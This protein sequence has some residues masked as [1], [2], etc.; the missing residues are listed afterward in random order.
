MAKN[1]RFSRTEQLIGKPALE[2]LRG[3]SVAVF[4]IGGVGCYAAEAL[5]RSGVG[6]LILIDDDLVCE[7]NINRQ[8]HALDSTVGMP[9][10]EAMRNRIADIN[11]AAVV[12]TLRVFYLPGTES[13]SWDYDYVIDAVDTV[14]AK[15]DIIMESQK[16]GVP[17]I[18]AMGAGNKL[19][20]TKFEIADIY[21]TSICPL[22]KV[23]R[24]EL[25]K[26]GVESL[27]VVYS[28]EPPIRQRNTLIGCRNGCICPPGTRRTC[29][30]RRQIPASVAFVPSVMGL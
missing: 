8:L 2:R 19:D 26:R 11:P 16:R 27:K 1:H 7:T 20:P 3:S 18:S 21:Q 25:K 29:T 17:V 9:K 6:K 22:A 28:K 24:R 12:E 14:T 23:M 10:V 13:V 5:A 15:L 4:G 30:I